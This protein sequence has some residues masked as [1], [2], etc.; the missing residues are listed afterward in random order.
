V[1]ALLR[2]I[3]APH[4]LVEPAFHL[5]YAGAA[6]LLFAGKALAARRFRWMAY[7]ASA[8]VSITPLTLFHFH[9]YALGGSVMTMLLTPVVFAMLL[10][11]TAICAF[12]CDALFIVLGALHRFSTLVNGVA[13]PAWGFFAA[14]PPV[15]MIIGYGMSIVVLALARGRVRAVLILVGMLIPL[16]GAWIV[17]RGDVA[18]PRLTMLD[19]SGWEDITIGGVGAG[20]R[21]AAHMHHAAATSQAVGDAEHDACRGRT[22]HG[23]HSWKAKDDAPELGDVAAVAGMTALDPRSECRAV[24]DS[25]PDA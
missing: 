13:A 17:G 6:A 7:A 1:A 18:V 23:F 5:T 2:L 12:P 4:D 19:V 10:V 21:T 3:I 16:T 11:S 9:Q 15:T 24:D 25:T 14:P 22:W 8:E 20:E